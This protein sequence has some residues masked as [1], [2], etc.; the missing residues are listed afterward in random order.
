MAAS[1]IRLFSYI[2]GLV[3]FLM[4]LPAGTALWYGENSLL[5][6]FLIPSVVGIVAAISS[7]AFFRKD[8]RYFSA[9][10]AI[11]TV[12]GIWVGISFFGAIPLYFSGC[13]ASLTDAFFESVSG[14]T[15]TGAS[16]V[17]NVEGLPKCIN[18][19][20]CQTHWIGGLGVI[21]L[22]VAIVPLVG[23]GGFR[24]IK[25]ESTGLDK[26]KMTAFVSSTAKS[27]WIIYIAM[28]LVQVA[29][30]YFTGITL[31]DSVAHAF[32]SM[33]TG[34]FSTKNASF[35]AF[36]NPSAEWICAA[37]MLLSSVNYALYYRLCSGRV[38]EV[39]KDTE[40]RV[41][42]GILILAF[43]AV[44]AFSGAGVSAR[45]AVF[46]IAAIVSST[47]FL[48]EDYLS[49]ASAAQA[50]LL[51][52]FF[53][54]GC[55][56]STAGGVKV[57]RWVILFKQMCNDIRRMVHPYRVFTLRLNGASGREK[58]VPLV[59]GFLA[60][61]LLIV[62]ITTFVGAVCG[63]DLFTAFTAAASMVGNVGPAFGSLG[64]T[65]NYSELPAF[66]KW[67]YMFA[68]LAG[69]LE[70]YTIFVLSGRL[71]ASASDVFHK[72]A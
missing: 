38:S 16:I 63:L 54:G 37:F 68:M 10:D 48:S 42:I 14:F 25:A 27:L 39:L 33:G 69:R 45:A 34:G 67:W 15:T 35:G 64:P 13:F 41:F 6:V 49:W 9:A 71:I 32:S 70:I 50:V 46:Q 4:L 36:A 53:I 72:K 18:L 51:V 66:L 47:G 65:S 40:L 31:F 17:A 12:G 29:L 22:A 62:F 19:W 28:T 1:F 57:V 58:L 11:W 52:L 55:S 2:L 23:A 59:A 5:P 56:G 26:E 24:L 3:G 44:F 60:S 61:Y 43:V 20:R 7:R 8:E 30:L 21:A